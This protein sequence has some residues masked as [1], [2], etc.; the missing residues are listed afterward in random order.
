MSPPLLL[1]AIADPDLRL[2][3]LEGLPVFGWRVIT[4]SRGE[5]IHGLISQH[6]P[7]ALLLDRDIADVAGATIRSLP[8]LRVALIPE[9]DAE[10]ALTM[11]RAFKINICLPD[12]TN[13]EVLSASLDGMLLL[14]RPSDSDC[15]SLVKARDGELP[16]D[17][18]LCQ[19]TWSLTPPGAPAIRLSQAET[20]FLATLAE[21]P[22]T[23]VSRPAM[24]AALGHNLDYYDSRRLDTLV[25]R[26]RLKL[27]RSSTLAIPIRCIHSVGYAFAAPISLV[28]SG[29]NLPT[30]P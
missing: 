6:N 19:T 10:M 20:R 8:M 18:Q 22:G 12:T 17:W 11:L 3:L 23:P 29:L 1:A 26:L 25:S 28:T 21:N 14:S 7:D 27:G 30:A 13:H 5:E 2:N 16:K 15:D 24:I 4:A 9:G